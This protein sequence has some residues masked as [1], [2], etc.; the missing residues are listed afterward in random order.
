MK[1][2]NSLS[3]FLLIA[4][5][6]V[7]Y[8]FLSL[9]IYPTNTDGA[10]ALL[11]GKDISDGN[12]LLKGWLLSTVPFYFTEAIFYALAIAFFGYSNVLAFIIPPIM[13]T[14]LICLMYLLSTNKKLA[15]SLMVFFFAFPSSM[16]VT[17]MLSVCIHMGTYIFVLLCLI[18]MENYVKHEKNHRLYFQP[19]FHR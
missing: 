2:I 11:I 5:M 19:Y 6:L 8:H 13:Y 10:T 9:N 14:C 1:K 17:S 3:V 15:I 4:C 7:L 12:I 16:A 18:S